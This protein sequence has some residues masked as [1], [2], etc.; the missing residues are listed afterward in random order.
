MLGRRRRKR[1]NE[2]RRKGEGR[3]WCLDPGRLSQ[4]SVAVGAQ[5]PLLQA[6]LLLGFRWPGSHVDRAWRGCMLNGSTL[7][8]ARSRLLGVFKTRAALS[9]GVP[10]PEELWSHFPCLFRS[11]SRPPS[12]LL[13]LNFCSFIYLFFVFIQSLLLKCS[14]KQIFC[15]SQIMA[16]FNHV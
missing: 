9:L 10:G 4:T 5:R 7:S 3:G 12:L 16:T 14:V 2:K 6:A 1:E 8:W 13:F 11:Y 15:W